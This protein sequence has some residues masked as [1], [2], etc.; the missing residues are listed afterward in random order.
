VTDLIE[1]EIHL[2]E[3][4]A[5]VRKHLWTVVVAVAVAVAVI[6]STLHTF[7]QKPVYQAT[8]QIIIE[9]ETP[10]ILS[11]NRDYVEVQNYDE[12]FYPTQYK[13]LQ[14]RSLAQAVIERLRL[15]SHP[16]FAVAGPAAKEP[17]GAEARAERLNDLIDAL[18]ARVT[19]VPLKNTRLVNLQL[20]A[21][22]PKLAA[23]LANTLADL[24]IEQSMSLKVDTTR[25]EGTWLS[26]QA[27]AARRKLEEAE[28]TLQRFNEQNNIISLEQRQSLVLQKL[29]ELNAELTRAR[30][31]RIE[32][33]TRVNQL[34]ALRRSGAGLEGLQSMPEVIGS[35]IIQAKRAELSRLEGDLVEQAKVYTAKHPK[36]IGLQSQIQTLRQKILEE[37]AVVGEGLRN[38]HDVAVSRERSLA[39]A[40]EEQQRLVQ[41]LNQK[42]IASGALKREVE[43]NRQ[44]FDVI[45]ARE[46]ETGLAS[47]MRSNHIR[48]LD[49]AVTP[50]A[51]AGP[52]K[53]RHLVLSLV[54]GLVGGVG[55]AFFLEYLDDTVKDHHDLERTAHLPF[56]GPVPVLVPSDKRTGSPDLI[57]LQEPKSVYAEAYRVVRT[58]LLFS[59]PDNPPRIL[60]VTSPGPQEGKSVTSVNLAMTMALGEHRVLLIDGDLRKPRLHKV[61]GLDNTRGLSNVIRGEI[62]CEQA[63]Q[64]T[65]VRGLTVIT[66]GRVPPN[67]SELLGS[68]RMAE[69]LVHLRTQFDRIIVDCTPIISVTDAA[70]LGARADGVILVVKAGAT[71]RHILQRSR[72]LL[73]DVQAK[74]VGAVL[75]QVDARKSAYYYSADYYARYYGESR[76][77]G[78]AVKPA[79]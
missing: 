71:R 27:V 6:A 79:G 60:V 69:L 55:L 3:Y 36:I 8:A 50:R 2:K 15:E 17:A 67:P 33:E 38:E 20:W 58:S 10:N 53:L 16:E 47:G 68:A 32:L 78:K 26:E 76:P 4:L 65:P 62:S 28:Q 34:Q 49:R 66:S 5:V 24:Y 54:I 35:P 51:P 43:V 41:E 63:Y 48:I 25:R 74:I 1:T 30:T 72:Q 57:V 13:I 52:N 44:I 77:A 11:L 19:V 14:S 29:E 18:L 31:A 37:I 22:E 9:K 70:V 42:S 46:K 56:L 61:F 21:Y 12:Q 23:L 45:L 59:S 73:D 64:K 39:A 40:L 75:N 7:R